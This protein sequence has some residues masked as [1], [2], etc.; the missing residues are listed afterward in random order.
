VEVSGRRALSYRPR[1]LEEWLK[2]R[3][4]CRRPAESHDTDGTEEAASGKFESERL[5]ADKRVSTWC[6]VGLFL[7]FWA[8]IMGSATPFCF[9]VMQKHLTVERTIGSRA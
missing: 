3:F 5:C 4:E 7:Y 6:D 8:S 2:T 9:W 1:G